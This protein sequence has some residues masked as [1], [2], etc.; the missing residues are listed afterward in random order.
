[1]GGRRWTAAIV[2]L[3]VLLGATDVRADAASVAK[4]REEART[5]ADRGYAELQ[6]GQFDKAIASFEKAE[7]KFHAPTILL[8]LA[9]A[10][11]RA[12]KLTAARATYETIVGEKLLSYAPKEFFDAQEKAHAALTSLA[13]RIPKLTIQVR[14]IAPEQ[15]IITLNG[16]KV[17]TA[18]LGHAMTVDPGQYVISH[19]TPG[20]QLETQ[21]VTL[22]EKAR[23]TVTLTLA[24]E[25]SGPSETT[26]PVSSAPPSPE[27][28]EDVAPPPPSTDDD[29]LHV[30]PGYALLGLGAA[31]VAV[32]AVTGVL[33]LN[34]ASSI[35]SQCNENVCPAGQYTEADDA[36]ALGNISTGAFIAGA[37]LIGGG[38]LWLS[39]DPLGGGADASV[40]LGPSSVTL[41]GRF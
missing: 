35:K 21:V 8:M 17:P 27:P 4:A 16:A 2:A 26:T 5:F 39:L 20:M 23:E 14:G 31:G 41:H 33:T 1:M 36:K 30:V 32:G 15:A 24:P 10:Q 40:G 12:G 37:A 38:L 13:G 19:R 25:A 22:K 7:A 9:E 6:R 11:I 34:K 29:T 28:P 3:A 18:S